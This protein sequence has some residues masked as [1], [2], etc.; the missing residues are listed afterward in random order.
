LLIALRV[1]AFVDA[2]ARG[3]LPLAIE[4]SPAAREWAERLA[5]A[6]TPDDLRLG[7]DALLSLG[8]LDL[9][10]GE[11]MA[12]RWCELGL[13]LI[14]AKTA[15]ALPDGYVADLRRNL[16]RTANDARAFAAGE[17]DGSA[18]DQPPAP[19][20]LDAVDRTPR[21]PDAI[22]AVMA[23]YNGAEFLPRSIASV[24]AQRELP[25]ELILVD[26]GSTDH[27]IGLAGAIDTP[28]PIRVISQPNSGQSAARNTGILAAEGEYIA[29]IDQDDE[30]Q[31]DHLA[32]LGSQM[33]ADPHLAWVYS[34]FDEMDGD[35]YTVTTHLMSEI[36]VP[37]PRHTLT[38]LLA[39]D[40]MALPSASLFR[41]SAVLEHGGFDS[42][43]I[44]YED[45]D[46]FVRL[47]RTGWRHDFVPQ[48]TVRYR[49]HSAGASSTGA[50]LRSRLIFMD[51]LLDTIPDDHRRNAFLSQDIILPRFFRATM[52]DYATAIAAKDW[53][54][55]RAALDALEVITARQGPQST[56]RR[57]LLR[58][59]RNPRRLR[60]LLLFAESRPRLFRPIFPAALSILGRSIVR[61]ER[62]GRP[63]S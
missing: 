45:D 13:E 26:D 21:R 48:S 62:M 53:E 14:D 36:G 47:Y 12:A 25:C 32:M 28:F 52:S 31:S 10:R 39:S 20:A 3:F 19:V 29:L 6:T 35:G 54:G 38:S 17:G 59:M 50:F 34:D 63:V 23:V 18:P 9:R 5:K 30:W 55:C 1:R 24:I 40:I 58:L 42:R 46:L 49:V 2:L 61:A 37:H 33:R 4:L 22:S 7:F 41:R 8:I 43:L 51:K 60:R 11:V 15:A 57:A 56:R 27:G 44:G 16:L